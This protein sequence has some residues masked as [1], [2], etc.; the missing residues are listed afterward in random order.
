M[1]DRYHFSTDANKVDRALVHEWISGQSYWARGRTRESQGQAFT[2]SRNYG[3][4]RDTTGEQVAYARVVTDEVTIAYLCDVFVSPTVR[5]E[6]IGKM[7]VAGVV[8]DVEQLNV[9]RFL[10][11]TDDAQ[12]LYEQFGFE[13]LQY[14]NRMMERRPVD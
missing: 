11:S 9:K 6:G 3:V 8:G 7:L 1:G 12:G 10:L 13:G 14:P 4:Y 2:A 5:G